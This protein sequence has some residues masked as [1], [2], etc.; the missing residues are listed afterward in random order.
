MCIFSRWAMVLEMSLFP[1]ARTEGKA[2]A[3]IQGANPK[4]LFF[5][6]ALTLLC[7]FILWQSNGLLIFAIVSL[8]AIAMGKLISRKIGGITGDTLGA[9]NEITETVVLLSILS[10]ERIG[11]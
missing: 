8:F 2:K 7:A 3:Y 9:L 1:Y 11:I 6:L 4:I 10:I 5:A